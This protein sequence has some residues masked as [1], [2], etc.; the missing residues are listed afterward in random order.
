MTS[1]EGQLILVDK[2]LDWTSFDVV[3]KL[4]YALKI[5]KIGHAGTLDPLATGLLLV[6]VGKYTK[7]LGEL[8]G[9]DK[10]YVG[11][12]EIG[13]TTPSF[14]LETTFDSECSTDHIKEADIKKAVQLLTGDIE[15]VPPVYSAIKVGGQR[16]YNAARKKEDIKL[17]P[18]KVTIYSFEISN[19]DQSIVSFKIH[20]SKG[21]YIRSV[22]RDFG[23]AL[24]VGAYLKSLRRNK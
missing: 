23:K 8:Q 1:L 4:R 24:G 7:M 14:D 18:R 10:T 22:A 12:F 17:L 20:C 16:A 13:K 3:N 21:T 15:Q 11:E 5:K 6:G 2:A 19:I 9:L